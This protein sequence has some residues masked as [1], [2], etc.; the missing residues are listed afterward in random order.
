MVLKQRLLEQKESIREPIRRY[1][2][3]SFGFDLPH[4]LRESGAI[5]Q[6]ADVV[7]FIYRP[8][9]FNLNATRKNETWRTY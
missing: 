2:D 6:D 7:M 4:D 9:F 8:N 5:E 3:S 1:A